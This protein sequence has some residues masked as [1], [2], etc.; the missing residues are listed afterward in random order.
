MTSTRRLA[1]SLLALSTAAL[2]AMACGSDDG[3]GGG[4]GGG[5]AGSG[6]G[7]GSC[8]PSAAEC[9]ATD[10][11][12]PGAACLARADNA[13][14]ATAQ[15]RVTKLAVTSPAV[16]AQP[17]MQDAIIT[18]KI[19]FSQ[20]RCAQRGT[21]QFGVLLE[22]DETART[23]KVGGS[24]PQ[25][26]SGD[27]KLD[28]TCFGTFHDDASGIDVAPVTSPYTVE[29]DRLVAKFDKVVLPIFLSNT[30]DDYV[31]LPLHQVTIKATL[32]A[33]KNCIGSFDASQ[34][35]TSNNCAPAEGGFAWQSGGSLEGYIT[36]AEAETVDIVSLAQTLC[37]VLS[38]DTARWK[39]KK[40]HPC[41]TDDGGNTITCGDC[42]TA[43]ENLNCD[44][45]DVCTPKPAAERVLPDGDYCSTTQG[46]AT[47]TC[48]DAFLLKTELSAAAIKIA[49]SCN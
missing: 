2:T 16:L 32:S 45:N 42:S 15:L 38:G 41:G 1:L 18:K 10:S 44:E 14:A 33:D 9:Y 17:F 28:G 31:L 3:G 8:Q 24:L 49:P 19:D 22:V 35:S 23:L 20:P 4:G 12:G 27:P 7:A 11:S 13:G 25:A 21:G 30:R 26:L 29:G 43:K 37:V 47:A 40:G 6:G 39:G 46:P 48:K 36:V 5:A 34:L